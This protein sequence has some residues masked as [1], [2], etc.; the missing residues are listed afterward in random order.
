[1][2][3]TVQF[4]QSNPGK[5]KPTRR[6]AVDTTAPA[7]AQEASCLVCG[8]AHAEQRFVQRG[9]P[10]FRCT[11]C[12]LEFVAPIPS[13]SELADY[14]NRGYAVPLERY[15]AAGRRNIARIVD[16]ERW[17]PMRGRLLEL[18]ASYGHSLALARER[19][20]EVVGVELSPAA[21]AHAR[22]HFGLDV[23]NCDLA[24]A[25]LADGSFDAVI[26]W[27]VLEHVRNPKSQLL[28]LAALLKPGGTLGLRVPNIASFGARTAGQWWPWMCPP[29]HLWFF[30]SATLP[31][32]LRDCGFEVR[33][34][35]TLRGDGNNLYQYALMAAGSR[36][37]DLRLRLSGGRRART[38]A[39]GQGSPRDRI[40]AAPSSGDEQA[41]SSAPLPGAMPPADE[42][43][44]LL[45]AWLRLLTRAQ[46]IT[47]ALARGTRPLIDP[48]ERRGWGDELLVYARRIV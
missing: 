30:S 46:P 26:G 38:Q 21:S 31:R 28:R 25:P 1:V 29:A 4:V 27:H 34:V 36:L 11:G 37:N 43:S 41:A 17:C 32:L 22:S 45:Q 6:A 12:G 15:A 7:S 35:K 23:F 19:G 48:L 39:A 24:D 10:V 42:P 9:Y 18:G 3:E 33:E 44:G 20:W 16:L 13:P 2:A 14:Y 40:S 47:D 5:P 8:G